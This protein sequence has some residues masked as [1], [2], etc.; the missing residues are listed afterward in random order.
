MSSYF[1]IN[2]INYEE[3]TDIQRLIENF[4]YDMEKRGLMPDNVIQN[5]LDDI[6][7]ECQNYFNAFNNSVASYEDEYSNGKQEGREEVLCDLEDYISDLEINK[8]E[9]KNSTNKNLTNNDEALDDGEVL[10]GVIE[11]MKDY[12]SYLKRR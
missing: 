5:F 10:A 1:N 2:E 6:R 8:H 9:V 11:K 12:I 3:K 4:E 7:R